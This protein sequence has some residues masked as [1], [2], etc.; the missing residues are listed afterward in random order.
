[1]ALHRRELLRAMV[2]YAET[3]DCRHDTILRYFEDE[4]EAFGGC[5]HCDNC[6]LRSKG[7]LAGEPDEEASAGIVR[8]ALAAIRALPFAAGA[9]AI[10]AFLT[11]NP[12]RQVQKY[13]WHRRD[14]FGLMRDHDEDWAKRLLRRFIAGG[15]L[16]VDAEHATLHVTRRAVDVERGT[17]PNPVR[18]PPA[19]VASVRTRSSSKP[20]KAAVPSG[21]D[22][23]AA[24]LFEK[25]KEWRRSDR[26][27]TTHR[28]SRC[29]TTQ[30]CAPS[31]TRRPRRRKSC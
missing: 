4:A 11:G 6:R 5:G 1:L 28:R 8:K 12:S 15:L 27:P 3:S 21:L 20:A 18:L 17:R 9:G 23:Y 14:A 25:L 30:R 19:R 10:A 29:S 16:A 7:A 22:A 24:G 26:P 13:D 31:R 2:G